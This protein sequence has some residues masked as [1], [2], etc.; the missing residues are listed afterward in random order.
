MKKKCTLDNL[1]T[2]DKTD[3]QENAVMREEPRSNTKP[4]KIIKKG[5]KRPLRSISMEILN[6]RMA[7]HNKRMEVIDKKK[8]RLQKIKDRYEEEIKWKQ[9]EEATA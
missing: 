8:E 4:R 5:V 1:Q 6:K 3:M 2:S 9:K 7:E